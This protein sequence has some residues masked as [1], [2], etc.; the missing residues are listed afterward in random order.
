MNLSQALMLGA[1]GLLGAFGAVHL[2][3]TYRGNKLEPRDPALRAAMERSNLVITRQTTVWRAGVG[4]NASHSLGMIALALVYGHLVLVRPDVLAASPF[5]AGLG[6]AALLAYLV[7]ARRYFF[8]IPFRG[9]ALA[10]TLYAAGWAL[11]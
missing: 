7:L 8:S 9:M 1:A 6:L 11:Q 5:L 3:Y 10:S 4:F 2:L